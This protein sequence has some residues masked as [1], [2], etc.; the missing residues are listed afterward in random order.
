[1][2]TINL[3]DLSIEDLRALVDRAL[4]EISARAG[5][6]RRIT[7]ATP[8]YNEKR[9]GAPWIARVVSWPVGGKAEI[10]FGNFLG[11]ARNGTVGELEIM[12]K[13]GDVVRWGQKDNR[14]PR[15]T[16]ANWGV[17]AEDGSIETVT[18]SAARKA[19]RS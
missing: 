9:Y 3:S 10:Q 14:N 7:L 6:S 16:E 2:N 19:F 17:V 13:P 18:E 12:A 1:M 8:A 11:D 15:Y 4:A 5:A